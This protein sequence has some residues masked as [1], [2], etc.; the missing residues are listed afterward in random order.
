VEP[1]TGAIRWR[2][3]AVTP[4]TGGLLATSGGLVLAGDREGCLF[5]PTPVPENGSLKFQTGGRIASPPIRY[6]FNGR[7]YVA[8]AAGSSMMAFGLP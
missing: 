8:V 6:S 3:D 4:L 1:N 7:Q 5:A 2:F